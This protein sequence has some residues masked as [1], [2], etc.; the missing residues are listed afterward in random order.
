MTRPTL[1]RYIAR[2]S[3]GLAVPACAPNWPAP[4]LLYG[5]SLRRERRRIDARTQLR[6]AHDMFDAMGMD[7][8]AERARRELLAT[9]ETA[10]KRTATATGPQLTPQEEQIARLAARRPD[11]P[12]D[13]RAPV[14]QRQNRPVS[15]E[16]GVHQAR[17]QLTQPAP[18][19]ISLA[20]LCHAG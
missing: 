7:A 12:R 1:S 15:P 18:Y 13:R 20:S 4:H 19:G 14:H 9:G 3:S 8:F 10:R 11:Q 2:Q 5:E 16:Q 6:I 17:H